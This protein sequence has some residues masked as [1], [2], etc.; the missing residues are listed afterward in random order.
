MDTSRAIVV[1]ISQQLLINHHL[2]ENLTLIPDDSAVSRSTHS[3]GVGL[4]NMRDIVETRQGAVGAQ[5]VRSNYPKY[6]CPSHHGVWVRVKEPSQ[7]EGD[8][9]RRPLRVDRMWQ[10][11]SGARLPEPAAGPQLPKC[12]HLCQEK[13][14]MFN[15]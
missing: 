9:S 15:V 1:S 13:Q 7:A 12:F 8:G 4:R 14:M 5:H 10:N 11:C 2:A 6:R 3:A